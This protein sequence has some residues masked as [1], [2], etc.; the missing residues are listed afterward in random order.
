MYKKWYTVSQ[1]VDVE[2][3]ELLSKS[4]IER[5]RWVKVGSSYEIEYN[6][7]YNTK[8]YT[9]EYERNRQTRIEF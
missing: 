7:N 8:K 1:Y 9:N 5:E 6:D 4:Q 2:T 3:G